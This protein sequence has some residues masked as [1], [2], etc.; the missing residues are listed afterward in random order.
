MMVTVAWWAV[1]ILRVVFLC[2]P[3]SYLWD[4]HFKTGTCLN[5][6][7]AYLSIS[8]I[9]LALDMTVIV[10]PMPILWTLQMPKARKVAVSAIFGMG[11]L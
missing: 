1:S 6:Q 9:N 11:V 8:V 4:Q 2:Q 7:A 10:L 5:T 3:I